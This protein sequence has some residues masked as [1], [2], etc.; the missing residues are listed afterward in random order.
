MKNQ[1]YEF[2]FIWYDSRSK[3]IRITTSNNQFN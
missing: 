1:T 3:T 2:I